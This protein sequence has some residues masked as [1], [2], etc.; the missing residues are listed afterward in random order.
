M[1]RNKVAFAAL[2]AL[3]VIIAGILLSR[4]SADKAGASESLQTGDPTHRRPVAVA[5]TDEGRWLFVANQRSGSVSVVN[6]VSHKVVNE[7]NVGKK[8]SDLAITSDGTR[9]V[10]VD[11]DAGALVVF[12]RRGS[13]LENPQRLDID[14]SAVS[15]QIVADGTHCVVASLWSRRLTLIELPQKANPRVVRTINLAFAPRMQLLLPESRKLVV[16]DSFGGRLA[17]VNWTDGKVES[18]RLLPAHNIRGLGL[19][20]DGTR[21]LISHQI[22]NSRAS[23]SRDDVHWGNLLTN[24]VRELR[25]AS[26]LDPKAD[27]LLDSRLHRL[28]DVG[29]GAADPASVAAAPG[30]K[31]VVAL[32]GVSEVAI[33]GEKVGAWQRIAV[34]RRPTAVSLSP[35]GR[36]AYV[37]NTHDDK[38]SVLDLITQKVNAEIALGPQAKPNVAD[39]GE[40]L[41][42]DARLSHD[43]WFSC[44]SCHTDGHTNGL[45]ADTLGDGSYGT[46][47][48]V[49]TLLGVRDTGPWAWNGSV[50]DLH[51]Q[52]RKSVATTMQGAKLKAG[53]DDELVAYMKTL[54]SAP[55][56]GRLRQKLD[57]AVVRRGREVFERQGCGNCHVPPTYTSPRMFDVG[58]GEANYKSFNPPS[59]R[60]V[61]QG[62]PFFHDGR[63][64]TLAEIFTRHRHPTKTELDSEN[65]VALLAFL[66]SL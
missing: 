65:L 46:P 66:E 45:L 9:L 44:H 2:I 49:L 35:D 30:G 40:L 31:M 8:L 10:A 63:A 7:V 26:V 16:A 55:P 18:D 60:G 6:V 42:Y 17:V 19:N 56:L 29:R 25:L 28:G 47:K 50:S 22:L 27:L 53:Q 12:R 38:V 20:T 61:S 15:V 37:A 34:G 11:E 62:G 58:S 32:A 64:G 43:G 54:V 41:F 52:V 24:G 39:R 1:V 3:G 51:T 13:Q 48:R 36:R 4:P 5:L 21:L 57:E 23:S 14:P 33:G 59:L